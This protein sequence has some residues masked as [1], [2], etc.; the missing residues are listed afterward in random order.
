MNQGYLRMLVIQ[1][2][3]ETPRSG[4]AIVKTIHEQTGWKPSYGSIYPLLEKLET[5]GAVTVHEEG[6]SKIYSL[7][8]IGKE[9]FHDE[10][11]RRKR[12]LSG[13]HEQLKVLASMGDEDAAQMADII[14]QHL[15]KAAPMKELPELV[16]MRG[17]LHRLMLAG[18]F[19]TKTKE[20]RAVAAKATLALKKL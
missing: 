8:A 18:A 1:Q 6:R 2:L 4:Y 16:A 17:E 11:A 19:Q 20:I 7:S 9:R 14:E 12:A 5:E 13:I 10:E 15:L 3:Q